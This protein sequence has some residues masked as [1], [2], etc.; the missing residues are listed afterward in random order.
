MSIVN[1]V[2]DRQPVFQARKYNI[3]YPASIIPFL[4]TYAKLNVANHP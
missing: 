2:S 1:P 3:T 4:Q